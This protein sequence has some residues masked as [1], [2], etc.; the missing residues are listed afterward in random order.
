MVAVHAPHLVRRYSGP[1][2]RRGSR[3]STSEFYSES[4][5]G[6]IGLRYCGI[7]DYGS[8]CEDVEQQLLQPRKGRDIIA[9]GAGRDSGQAVGTRARKNK[10]PG[11]G[12]ISSA[13]QVYVAPSGARMSVGAHI[14]RLARLRRASPWATLWRASGA[15]K[16][17]GSPG[18]SPSPL[19]HV[20]GYQP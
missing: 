2:G 18:G 15:G 7:E 10:S 3:R 14:P 6:P 16:V 20:N 13:G 17:R 8:Q 4:F 1:L 12:N 5:R 9:H 11:R 19:C